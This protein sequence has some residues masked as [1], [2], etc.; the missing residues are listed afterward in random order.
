MNIKAVA[1]VIV[2]FIVTSS[3]WAEQTQNKHYTHVLARDDCAPWD[4]GAFRLS[5]YNTNSECDAKTVP[6][7]EIVV[8]RPMTRMAHISLDRTMVSPK[9]SSPTGHAYLSKAPAKDA[10]PATVSV[11][12]VSAVEIRGSLHLNFAGRVEVGNFI[13]KRCKNVVM[14]G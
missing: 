3:G 14:C 7:F 5:F 9:D 2:S 6:E 8:W 13:A 11:S 4:G 10:S 1:I 12:E